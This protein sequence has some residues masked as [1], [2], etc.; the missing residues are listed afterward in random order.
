MKDQQLSG[1]MGNNVLETR[2]DFVRISQTPLLQVCLGKEKKKP[3]LSCEFHLV[4]N[5]CRN[6]L[7]EYPSEQ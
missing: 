1:I 3:N 7:L 4:Y 6:K 5:I 2:H